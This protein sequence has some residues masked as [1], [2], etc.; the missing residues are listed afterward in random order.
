MFASRA[1]ALSTDG[2]RRN[3][4]FIDG[5][6]SRVMQYG[7]FQNTIEGKFLINELGKRKEFVR[8]MYGAIQPESKD[9]PI[10]LSAMQECEREIDEWLT[11]MTKTRTAEDNLRE[12]RDKLAKIIDHR[13]PKADT[14]SHMIPKF[15]RDEQRKEHSK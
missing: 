1:G 7:N 10:M 8:N 4:E 6:L 12:E 15:M 2:L 13:K 3:L 9:A 11:R 14:G 5:E